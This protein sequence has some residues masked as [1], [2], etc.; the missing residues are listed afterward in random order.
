[1]GTSLRP[2]DRVGGYAGSPASQSL[3]GLLDLAFEL[4]G[5]LH[6]VVN[7]RW[8]LGAGKEYRDPMLLL[9]LLACR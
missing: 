9:Q 4:D 8:L 5:T 2:Q 7:G 3:I 1:V 6:C